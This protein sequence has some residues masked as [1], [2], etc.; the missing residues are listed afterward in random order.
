M[1]RGEPHPIDPEELLRALR[2]VR[3]LEDERLL[4]DWDRSLPFADGCFD[5]SE[6]ATRLGWDD[7]TSVYDSCLIL[8]DVRVG[9]HTWVGP[10]TL[11]DGSGGGLTIGDHCSISAGVHLY[12]HDTVL[13]SL[14]GGEAERTTAPVHVGHRC[15]LGA[16]AI[17]RAGV[18]IG[19]MC[20]IGAGSFVN[21]SIPARSVAVGSPARIIGRVD[22]NGAA[23]RLV[24]A[25]S[26][27]R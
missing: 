18:T 11:L 5:R 16:H 9:A 10:F 6:R 14:S 3:R 4:R 23:V 25:G 24:Y 26:E 27:G 12:T 20:V 8:G 21:R 2:A 7:G 17:V 15:H 19:D 13:R 1:G 22:G